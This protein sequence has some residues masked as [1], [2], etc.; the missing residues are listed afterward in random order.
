MER[1]ESERKR[2][3]KRERERERE[4][5]DNRERTIK[6]LLIYKIICYY[7]NL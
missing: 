4:R 2:E 6:E 7:D 3:R 1:R 5:R